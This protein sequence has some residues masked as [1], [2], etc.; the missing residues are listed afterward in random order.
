MG[1][2][3]LADDQAGS[4]QDVCAGVCEL[5]DEIRVDCDDP[6]LK[7]LEEPAKAITL[8]LEL[9]ER[10]AEA[11]SHP[12]DRPR[13]RPELVVEPGPKLPVEPALLD[14]GRRSGHSP[15]ASRD[16]QCNPEPDQRADDDRPD[17]RADDLIPHD[18]ESV[19]EFRLRRDRDQRSRI[20]APKW[21]RHGDEAATRSVSTTRRP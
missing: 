3:G 5:D 1:S 4:N 20:F 18:S 10:A 9:L 8:V 6:L 19:L 11:L 12:V 2:A 17:R 15:Q 21:K 13:E 14:V 16:E 7:L